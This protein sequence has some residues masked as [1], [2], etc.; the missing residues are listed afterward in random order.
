MSLLATH[1]RAIAA[2]YDDGPAR[3]RCRDHEGRW[4]VMHA[5]CMDE[6]DPDSQIAVVIEPA[7]SADIAPIIVEA[8]GLTPREREVLRGIARGLSTPEIAAALFLSSHT[9]RD[10]IKSVFEKTGVGSRG[11]LTAKLFAEHYLD[12][13]QASAVFV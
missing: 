1:A 7:Q 11:E 4:I 12:D 9:V 13:F 5:S 8:Y 6:T 10:Y 3:L 2:G